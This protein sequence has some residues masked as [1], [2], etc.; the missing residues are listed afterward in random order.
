MSMDIF[1]LS[2]DDFISQQSQTVRKVDENLFDP[3]VSQGQNGVYKAILRLVPWHKATKPEEVMPKK[4]SV[5]LKNPLTGER[6]WVDDPSSVGKPSIFWTIDS[7]LKALEKSEPSFVEEI[8]KN[9][10]RNYKYF[11]LAYIK[12]DPQKPELQGKIKVFPFGHGI[13]QLVDGQMN[14]A[15][16]DLGV[17]EKVNPFSLLKGKDFVYV[18]KKKTQSWRDFSACK[19]MEG[20]TTPLIITTPSGKEVAITDDPKVQAKF[21]EFLIQESPDLSQYFYKEWTDETYVKVVDFLRAAIPKQILDE[22]MST[23]KD[24][25]LT[26]LYR[27]SINKVAAAPTAA[28]KPTN[29]L[30]E[31]LGL[32]GDDIMFSSSKTS[33]VAAPVSNSA[34]NSL[35]DDMFADL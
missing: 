11:A 21:K 13:W 17:A 33:E 14:P 25:K 34:A 23:C 3:D 1:N 7:K 31:D 26:D 12:K 29:I 5:R 22:A 20:A 9:F 2:A 35:D 10:Y 19:F 18:A 24:T 4:Y 6:F 28:P 30:D 32:G 15:D 16:A 27:S 8:K